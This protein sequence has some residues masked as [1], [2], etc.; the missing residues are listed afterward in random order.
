MSKKS[1]YT[2]YNQVCVHFGPVR[3]EHVGFCIGKDANTLK[4]I[5]Y[6]TGAFVKVMQPDEN[7][8]YNWFLITGKPRS[9]RHA[10]NWLNAV[11]KEAILRIPHSNQETSSKTQED[12]S[13]VS[14]P[15]PST[16]VPVVQ[17]EIHNEIQNESP[18]QISIDMTKP[19]I[20]KYDSSIGIAYG[21]NMTFSDIIDALRQ[22]T[23]TLYDIY[24][25]PS[26]IKVAYFSGGDPHRLATKLDLSFGVIAT[27][28]G[29][30]E[31]MMMPEFNVGN[32]QKETHHGVVRV[33]YNENIV[34]YKTLFEQYISICDSGCQTHK[35]VF[36]YFDIFGRPVID[37]FTLSLMGI[38]KNMCYRNIGYFKWVNY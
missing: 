15:T 26:S 13:E 9:V 14:T 27:K 36:L 18:C 3:E 25:C 21:K 31:S 29:I 20:K 11:R 7:H 19:Y 22:D 16:S 4:Q 17:N 5:H 8:A 37:R 1:Q 30:L 6:K 33:Y 28:Y 10:R 38:Q 34:S 24:N 32:L 12:I 35:I 2:P 23:A